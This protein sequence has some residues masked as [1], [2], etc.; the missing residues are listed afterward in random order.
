MHVHSAREQ[1]RSL[2]SRPHET[3][4]AL[5]NTANGEWMCVDRDGNVFPLHVVLFPLFI[6][7]EPRIV[8]MFLRSSASVSNVYISPSHTEPPS[9][10]RQTNYLYIPS[11]QS[12]FSSYVHHKFSN[13]ES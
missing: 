1:I 2:L 10:Q 11:R 13:V 7:S 4:E 8:I 9:D 5:A 6:S 3:D 12:A